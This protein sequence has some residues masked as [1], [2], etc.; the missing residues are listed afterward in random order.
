[1]YVY[2]TEKTLETV[3]LA[4]MNLAVN[5]LCGQIQKAN[6]Y[7][8]DPRFL[9]YFLSTLHLEIFD[10]GSSNPTLNRNH[11]HKIKVLAP[12]PEIQ[13]RLSCGLVSS[14]LEHDL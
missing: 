6:T 4:R 1:M 7:Y 9:S 10:T 14:S 2:G 11:V 5:G 13:Q 12:G 3:K 8:E